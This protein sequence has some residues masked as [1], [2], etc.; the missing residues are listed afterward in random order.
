MPLTG[1]GGKIAVFET[2]RPG[3][4]PDGV[5]PVLINGTTVLDFAFDPFDT[6]RLAA[7]CDDG[8]IRSWKIPQGGLLQQ[9]NEPAVTF[10]AHG[11]KIQIVKWHPLAQDLLVTCAFDRTVKLWD[12]NDANEP[13]I[14]LE[15]KR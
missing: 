7:A 14:E 2:R 9:E 4:I 8:Y 6:T 12:L 3:R 11:D 13:K 10:P 15:V 5:T 1:P